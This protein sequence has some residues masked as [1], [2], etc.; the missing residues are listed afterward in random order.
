MR[1]IQCMLVFLALMA[2]LPLQPGAFGQS[3][4][5]KPKADQDSG[6]T[7]LRIELTGG[8]E[9]KPVAEASVYVK[10]NEPKLLG[11]KRVELN[12]KTNEEGVARSPQIPQGRIL[13][14]IV[15]PGWETFGQWYKVT[16]EKQTIPIHLKRPARRW[17]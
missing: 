13:I 17:Y 9:K 12:L 10:F 14:Q 5:D 4:T 6:T 11:D 2:L 16:K 8:Q 3:G 7:R 15:A 1:R